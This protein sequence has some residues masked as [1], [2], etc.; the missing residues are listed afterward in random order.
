MQYFGAQCAPH[1]DGKV[2]LKEKD[3]FKELH[4]KFVVLASN[5]LFGRNA[6][7][8]RVVVNITT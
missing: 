2:R 1:L 6:F 3:F 4:V 8:R 5:Q 7:G